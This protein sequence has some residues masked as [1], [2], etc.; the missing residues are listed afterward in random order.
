MSRK[1]EQ[2]VV[3]MRYVGI[4]VDLPSNKNGGVRVPDERVQDSF[5]IDIKNRCKPLGFE[6]WEVDQLSP[7]GVIGFMFE[8]NKPVVSILRLQNMVE[9]TAKE[10]GIID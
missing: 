2:P 1:T 3:S 10:F 5:E 9:K 7:S 4:G 8:V 6:L